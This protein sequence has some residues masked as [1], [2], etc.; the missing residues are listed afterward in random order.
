MERYGISDVAVVALLVRH[1]SW[2]SWVVQTAVQDDHYLIC[3]VN[4]EGRPPG[5]DRPLDHREEPV[6]LLTGALGGQ[7]AVPTHVEAL[8]GMLRL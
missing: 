1:R 2:P 8:Q 5:V 4:V 7:D 6:R 3:L